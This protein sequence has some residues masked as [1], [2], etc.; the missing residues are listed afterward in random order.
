MSIDKGVE[1]FA[2]KQGLFV[3]AQSG[4]NIQLLNN[5]KFVPRAFRYEAK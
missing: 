5:E 3:L 4:E 1:Q 2:Y